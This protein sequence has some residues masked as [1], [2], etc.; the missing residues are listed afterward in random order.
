MNRR[1]SPS[2]VF[3]NLHGRENGSALTAVQ[4][5]MF[6]ALHCII[7]G[8]SSFAFPK[9]CLHGNS[10]PSR[11]LFCTMPPCCSPP[12]GSARCPWPMVL[13][14]RPGTSHIFLPTKSIHHSQ[15]GGFSGPSR[16]P[17]LP[18]PDPRN[19]P[20]I[21]RANHRFRRS[22]TRRS[23]LRPSFFD[24]WSEIPQRVVGHFSAWPQ[25]LRMHRRTTVGPSSCSKW[26]VKPQKWFRIC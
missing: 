15:C 4:L 7:I 14:Y 16:L 24:E 2:W 5:G 17:R 10:K 13:C 12:S 11:S 26:L 8:H 6:A 23:A 25:S 21:R 20:E 1:S 9:V 19:R 22:E 18:R 3:S